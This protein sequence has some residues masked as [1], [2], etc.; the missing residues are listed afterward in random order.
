[1]DLVLRR[2]GKSH[3]KELRVDGRIILKSIS[4]NRVISVWIRTGTK[5]DCYSNRNEPT[6]FA[7]FEKFLD[8]KRK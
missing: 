7:K 2:E 8:Y 6:G 5:V 4:E 1:M 3:F